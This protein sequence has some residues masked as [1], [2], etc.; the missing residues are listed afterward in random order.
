MVPADGLI[1]PAENTVALGGPKFARLSKL[2]I[3]ILN[4]RLAFSDMVVFLKTEGPRL[5]NPA[6]SEF[7]CEDSHKCLGLAD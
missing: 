3:S 1:A 4:W 6:R 5:P 2:K 7:L